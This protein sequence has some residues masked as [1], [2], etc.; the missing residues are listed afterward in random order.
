MVGI[1]SIRILVVDDS[2][3]FLT[4]ISNQLE[5]GHDIV[6]YTATGGAEALDVLEST[7]VDCVV[8]D[9]EMPSMNGLE[10]HEEVAN[11]W[12]I[13]FI[14]LTSEGNEDVASNA[15]SAGVDDYLRKDKVSEGNPL[16][17]LVNRIENVVTQRQALER[18]ELLV[19]NSP[20][21]ILHISA[22]GKVLAANDAASAAYQE[23]PEE[24]IG[25]NLESLLPADIGENRIEHGREA[26]TDGTAKTFQDSF[27][28]K[29]FHNIAAPVGSGTDRTSFQLISRDITEQKRHEQE[30]QVRS[31]K[32]ELINRIVRHDIKNDIQ[33]LTSWTEIL[34]EYVEQEGEQY[35]SRIHKT[36]EH[37]E[38]L[39]I[40]SRDFV[41]SIA[42]EEAS[43][44]EP[45]GLRHILQN[46]IDKKRRA[47]EDAEIS[48]EGYSGVTVE[49]N[50][51][52]SSVFGNLL[53]NAIRHNDKSTPV[54]E[55]RI[56][57]RQETVIVWI[58]DNGPGIPDDQK[59][60]I[61]RRNEMG[62]ES[63]GSGL[64][65][66]L[67]DTLVDQF[68]GDIWVEDN[69]PEGSVFAVRLQKYTPPTG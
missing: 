50:E 60:T 30:L 9:Y 25:Q 5:S 23:E 38:E 17:V 51:L 8:S 1:E 44:L 31:E 29:H 27:N 48:V 16:E 49:A 65:L 63:P 4:L 3:F 21:E 62:T 45:V 11:R 39:T 18:Y 35:V 7:P 53:S 66:Y 28:Q 24:L 59:E 10:L 55:V 32:L 64:G 54:I 61:F 33:L 69:K 22:D 6:T 57:E 20:D 47:F 67:V 19:N 68:G 36:C 40:I 58:A 13:P 15:I 52:L 42:D 56:E 12:E 34:S 26:L 37:I 46:E 2:D 41:D 14:L 43:E